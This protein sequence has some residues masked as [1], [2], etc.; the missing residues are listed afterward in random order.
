MSAYFLVDVCHTLEMSICVV[1]QLKN[2]SFNTKFD[3]SSL[4]DAV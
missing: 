1:S 3:F 2:N 4:Y